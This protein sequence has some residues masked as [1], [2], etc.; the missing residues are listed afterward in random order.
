MR[1]V[2]DRLG[3]G[4]CPFVWDGGFGDGVLS[5]WASSKPEGT[6][7]SSSGVDMSVRSKS[8]SACGNVRDRAL[9]RGPA[10]SLHRG[11]RGGRSLGEALAARGSAALRR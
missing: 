3:K 10:R 9:I 6:S 5:I 2:I 11:G 1:D 8:G 4:Y 7:V